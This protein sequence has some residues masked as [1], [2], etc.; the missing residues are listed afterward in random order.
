MGA[1]TDSVSD[2]SVY[3]LSERIE[4]GTRLIFRRRN[5]LNEEN[6]MKSQ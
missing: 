1:E 5:T 3:F 6:G 4:A 2:V